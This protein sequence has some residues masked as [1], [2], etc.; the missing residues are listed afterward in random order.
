MRQ[1]VRDGP[2]IRLQ[3][4]ILVL[5][6]DVELDLDVDA[7]SDLIL[8]FGLT[9]QEKLDRVCWLDDDPPHVLRRTTLCVG[10]RSGGVP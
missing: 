8:M 1:R 10:T 9:W 2:H 3:F 4:V 6:V 7:P 5:G